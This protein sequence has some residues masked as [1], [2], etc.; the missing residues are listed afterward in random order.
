M[1]A[2][3]DKM[4]LASQVAINLGYGLARNA[5]AKDITPWVNLS[6]KLDI[7]EKLKHLGWWD[8]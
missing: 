6:R 2:K 3:L 8:D 4:M 1:I 7:V 5:A